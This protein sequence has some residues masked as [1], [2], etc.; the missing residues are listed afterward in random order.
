MHY[1]VGQNVFGDTY[2]VHKIIRDPNTGA[3]R[4]YLI[5]KKQEITLWKEFNTSM[6]ISIEFNIDF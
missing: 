3:L 4:V 5:N 1:I 2:K 6:P